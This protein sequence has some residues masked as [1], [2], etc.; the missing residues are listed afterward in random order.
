[1]LTALVTTSGPITRLAYN[2]T[3]WKAAPRRLDLDGRE[4]RLEGFHA[5]D[6]N[7]VSLT[8]PRGNRTVL[9]LIPATMTERRGNAVLARASSP[10]NT[11]SPH[12]LLT[13]DP[14]PASAPIPKQA[15]TSPEA[16]WE[17]DG[18]H[19]LIERS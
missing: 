13:E 19:L 2:L 8:D 14:R 12:D 11:A 1:M 16:R 9:L 6:Q 7:T 15:E 18:G 17:T 10:D 5:M 3:A 4:V